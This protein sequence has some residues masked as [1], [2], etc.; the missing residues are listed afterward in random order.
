MVTP[1]PWRNSLDACAKTGTDGRDR[2]GPLRPPDPAFP[3]Q[4]T[5]VFRFLLLD[6]INLG[7]RVAGRAVGAGDLHAVGTGSKGDNQ[8]GVA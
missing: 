5:R 8:G 4:T 2:N 7:Q 3:G 6:Q 1:A